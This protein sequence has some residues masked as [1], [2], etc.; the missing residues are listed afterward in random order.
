[1]NPC[2]ICWTRYEDWDIFNEEISEVFG[3]IGPAALPA[4]LAFLLDPSHEM[5]ARVTAG[6]AIAAIGRMRPET[7]ERCITVLTE[8]LA[9]YAENDPGFNAMVT[10]MLLDLEA[11]EALPLIKRV[12]HRRGRTLPPR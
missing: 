9:A 12:R 3:L 6:N 5:Y 7:R 4:L 10:S 8:C 11:V 1:M 2:A